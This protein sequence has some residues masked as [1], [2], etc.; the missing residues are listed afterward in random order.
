MTNEAP[1]TK[2][3]KE[4]Q[5]LSETASFT[6]VDMA[7]WCECDKSAIREWMHNNVTPHPIKQKHLKARFDLLR[8]ALKKY[9]EKL[10]VPFQ[11]KQYDRVLHVTQVRD[12]ALK[13][14]PKLDYSK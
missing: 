7:T 2:I 13:K 5:E 11:I 3:A 8:E 10:P 1:T 9:P 12:Y 6:M 14:L 4:L